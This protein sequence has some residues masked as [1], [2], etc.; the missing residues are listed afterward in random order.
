VN[1]A[2]PTCGAIYNVAAKDVGRK[3][4]CKK[5]NSALKVTDAG[6]EMDSGTG[7]AAPVS[8]P[9]PAAAAAAAIEDEDEDEPVVKKKKKERYERGP[10]VNPLVA[11]GGL[12][13]VLFG[14]GVFLVI[15]FTSFPIIGNAGSKRAGAYVDKLKMEQA[16]KIKN[17][18]PKGKK[19]GDLTSD[20]LKK[21]EEDSKKINEDYEKRIS[22]AAQDAENTK[23]SNIRDEWLEMYGLMF[24]F[25]FVAFGCIGYLRTEQPL[26]LK[27][28]AAV[29]LAIMML[30]MFMKFGFGGCSMP[31]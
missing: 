8:D 1:N 20:D 16:Q 28:V 26:T 4:K 11:I 7:S 29:V 22:E 3:L 17:L 25:L 30:I 15:V 31:R 18:I 2:C 5:C 14:F 13:T 24:G 6:L 27:I 21:I 19:P 10:G 12:P 23:I 9:K